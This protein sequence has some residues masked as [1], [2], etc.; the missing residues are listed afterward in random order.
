[1]SLPSMTTFPVRATYQTRLLETVASVSS[2]E[3]SEETLLIRQ[4]RAVL[5]EA[6]GVKFY[7]R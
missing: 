2:Q 4:I 3:L 7:E 5:L 6:Q 1:M